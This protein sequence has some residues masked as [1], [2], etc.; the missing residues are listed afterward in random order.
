[1]STGRPKRCTGNST[2]GLRCGKKAER[3]SDDLITRTHAQAPKGQDQRIGAA[4]AANG[5]LT[6]AKAG[7]GLLKP[8]DDRSADVLAAAQDI[9][10]SLLEVIPQI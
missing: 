4:V 7:K 1:M 8:L 6:A 10:H 5:M 2:D 3:S 9:Q